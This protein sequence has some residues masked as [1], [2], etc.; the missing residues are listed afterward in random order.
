MKLILGSGSPRRLDLLATL[1]LTPDAIR[2]PDIDETPGKGELPRPYCARMSREKARTVQA[3]ADEV[4][5]C[6]DTT[7]ALGR[8]IMGKPRDAGE[9][10]EFLLAMSGRRHKVITAVAVRRGDRL[11]ERD[12]VTTVRMKRLDDL[13]LN[14]YLATDDWRG[15]AG[16]YGIQGPA[17]AFIP[18]LQGSYTAVM[19][20]PVAETANLLKAAGYPVWRTE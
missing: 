2:P 3:G 9:A 12:V 11:W 15:K 1:G 4:V 16:G 7:V 10:A 5:L 20:L 18:W 14:A 17:G 6:A 13:E 8:R 19:G